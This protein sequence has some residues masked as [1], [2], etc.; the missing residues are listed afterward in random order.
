VWDPDQCDKKTTTTAQNTA[1]NRNH[2]LPDCI[3]EI[4]GHAGKN[5]F[6]DDF[7]EVRITHTSLECPALDALCPPPGD[8]YLQ[9]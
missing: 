6:D 7:F 9:A 2:L 5:E 4:D 3:F 1:P 8:G